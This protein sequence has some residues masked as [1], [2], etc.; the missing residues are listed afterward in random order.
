MIGGGQMTIL[1]A[2]FTPFLTGLPGWGESLTEQAIITELLPLWDNVLDVF[3]AEIGRGSEIGNLARVAK[4]NAQKGNQA[5]TLF[6]LTKL[7]EG[8]DTIPFSQRKVVAHNVGVALQNRGLKPPRRF[9]LFEDSREMLAKAKALFLSR[10]KLE[11]FEPTNRSAILMNATP[12]NGGIKGLDTIR[13]KLLE[14]DRIPYRE[15]WDIVPDEEVRRLFYLGV[16]II[17]EEADDDHLTFAWIASHG[18]HDGFVVNGEESM[19]YKELLSALD[20]IPGSKVVVLDACHSGYLI[21][22][23]ETWPART[24][25]SVITSTGL[26]RGVAGGFSDFNDYLAWFHLRFVKPL[27][28]MRFATLTTYRAGPLHQ[29]KQQPQMLLNFDAIL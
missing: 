3:E 13:Q 20:R 14:R 1:G 23:I 7:S 6:A 5:E 11:W 17:A 4:E 26:E 8:I 24:Q 21:P 28:R 12:L 9:S 15:I 22:F 29:H 18:N 2:T 10:P 16:K 25:Y 19:S 27:S